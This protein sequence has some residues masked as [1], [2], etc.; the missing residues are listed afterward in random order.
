RLSPRQVEQG[1][2][3]P[4]GCEIPGR[5]GPARVGPNVALERAEA[6]FT[7]SD[8]EHVNVGS[9]LAGGTPELEDLFDA[10]DELPASTRILAAKTKVELQLN[11]RRF[12]SEA[13]RQAKGTELTQ[14]REIDRAAGKGAGLKRVRGL[15]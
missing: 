3:F 14:S 15:E 1:M 6:S 12:G 2:V 7:E 13:H 10:S 4:H 5:V 11:R 9:K 8:P